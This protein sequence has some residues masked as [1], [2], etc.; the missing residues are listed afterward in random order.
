M[1]AAP[2]TRLAASA[3]PQGPGKEQQ[4]EGP[5]KGREVVAGFVTW[6]K[7]ERAEGERDGC[8][9]DHPGSHLAARADS[10]G[11]EASRLHQDDPSRTDEAGRPLPSPVGAKYRE[12]APAEAAPKMK[13]GASG[14]L[15]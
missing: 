6:A 9:R 13:R 14:M 3:C 15:A 5:G 4:K 2:A 11:E 1:T 10:S 8:G 7:V 12:V